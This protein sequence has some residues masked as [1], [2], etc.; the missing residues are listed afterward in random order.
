MLWYLCQRHT[1]PQSL[2]EEPLLH[3]VST[4]Q[5]LLSLSF[6]GRLAP[7]VQEAPSDWPGFGDAGLGHTSRPLVCSGACKHTA[8][9]QE[10]AFL[11]MGHPRARAAQLPALLTRCWVGYVT[12]ALSLLT[13]HQGQCRS[14]PCPLSWL[15]MSGRLFR[16]ADA[17]QRN[18]F[19]GHLNPNQS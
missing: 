7:W 14:I 13:A 11:A 1:S 16:G 17:F 2:G 5:L 12:C 3:S 19:P 15:R 9:C 4:I 10:K 8:A 6:W 18:D